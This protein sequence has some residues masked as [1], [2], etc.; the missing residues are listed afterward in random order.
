[1]G[2]INF[3]NQTVL[4]SYVI[5]QVVVF[6]GNLKTPIILGV[7]VGVGSG[8]SVGVAVGSAVAVEVGVGVG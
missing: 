7:G 1:M 5:E 6:P 2:N 8:V 4:A 3:K